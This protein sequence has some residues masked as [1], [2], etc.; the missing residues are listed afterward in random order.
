MLSA[1]GEHPSGE[2]ALLQASW[3]SP[4]GKEG[5]AVLAAWQGWEEGWQ[6]LCSRAGVSLTSLREAWRRSAE[7]GC[8][9]VRAGWGLPALA[10]VTCSLAEQPGDER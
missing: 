8:H 1:A 6:G 2:L 7:A 9:H 3:S 10:S 5:I 4:A